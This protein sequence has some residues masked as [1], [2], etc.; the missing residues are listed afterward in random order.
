M[1]PKLRISLRGRWPRTWISTHATMVA[2][3][4]S[5]PAH[6]LTVTCIVRLLAQKGDRDAAGSGQP[7]LLVL[8]VAGSDKTRY[9]KAARAGLCFGVANHQGSA[10]PLHGR[11]LRLDHSGPPLQHFPANGVAGTGW[12]TV[13]KILLDCH[14]HHATE[15]GHAPAH[16]RSDRWA[17]PK[18]VAARARFRLSAVQICISPTCCFAAKRTPPATASR[19]NPSSPCPICVHRV[20]LR[21]K[22]LACRPDVP[23]RW[24]SQR[25]SRQG[26]W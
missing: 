15:P 6:R 22:I 7:L 13:L 14:R 19:T 16:R 1:V 4:T 20:H 26:L 9:L 12:R 24:C 10:Q 2:W 18:A 23:D 5:R 21:L 17:C 11:R 3:C 25:T 8:P